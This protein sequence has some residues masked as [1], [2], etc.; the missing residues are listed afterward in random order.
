MFRRLLP[1]FV[2]SASC[3]DPVAATSAGSTDEGCSGSS[4]STSTSGAASSTGDDPTTGEPATGSTTEPGFDPP[5]AMCGDGYLEGDEECDDANT[6]DGDGCS[7]AC[8]VPCGLEVQVLALAPSG[9]SDLWVDAIVP[10]PDGGFVAVA[11]Q[12]EITSD[13]EGMQNI[14]LVR[15][16]VLRYGPDLAPLWDR[17]LAPD[18][19]ALEPDAGV[20]DALGDVYVAGSLAG[21]D[22]D[23]IHLVKL[24][25]D[26][27]EP[28]WTFTHDGAAVMSDDVADGLA[29]APDGD[30]VL[31]GHVGDVDKDDDVWVRKLAP[32]DGAEVWTTTWSGA[33]NGEYSNDK[34][35][36]V[37][38]AADGTVYVGAREYVEFD[39]SEA[40]L[41]KFGKDGG[42]AQK[43]FSPL[44]DG[45][46]HSHGPGWVAVDGAGA[47]LFSAVRLV[48]AVPN[49]WLYKL[50]ADLAVEWEK[51]LADFEDTGDKWAHAGARF[52]AAGGIVVAGQA[53]TKDKMAQLTWFDVWTARLDPAGTKLCQIHYTPAT[54]D[55]VPPSLYAL[56]VALAADGTALLG[57]Q[58]IENGEQQLW[59]GLFRPL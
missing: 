26:D 2:A 13:Q 57:G 53:R 30:L 33:G 21:Q 55:L 43:V 59:V 20:V 44:S 3:A 8:T 39:T 9:L 42:P 10:A 46:V 52:D 12:R 29:L 32:D 35:G 6:V 1:L 4:G 31:V 58:Q 18:D 34:G 47:V 38:V 14:G 54:V 11:H 16:R 36:R 22:G 49:F 41:L 27:G 51:Q 19:A 48:G 45:G 50:D 23:D 15:T 40:V 56:D 24:A 7:A 37:A 5:P 17:L 25:G 28:V